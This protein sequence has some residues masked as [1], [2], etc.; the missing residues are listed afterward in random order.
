MGHAWAVGAID[1]YLH[2]LQDEGLDTIE[3]YT[4]SDYLLMARQLM[5]SGSASHYHSALEQCGRYPSLVKGVQEAALEHHQLILSMGDTKLIDQTVQINKPMVIHEAATMRFLM[6]MDLDRQL[7]TL[8]HLARTCY[9]LDINYSDFPVIINDLIDTLLVQ[10]R[11]CGYT[12]DRT[13][14]IDSKLLEKRLMLVEIVKLLH[15]QFKSRAAQIDPLL[16]QYQQIINC[17]LETGEL[18][19]V[20]YIMDLSQ[21]GRALDA[22]CMN[23]TCDQVRLAHLYLEQKG[24]HTYTLQEHVLSKVCARGDMDALL[25][26]VTWHSTKGHEESARG[27]IRPWRYI[28]KPMKYDQFKRLYKLCPT[29]E[30]MFMDDMCCMVDLDLVL[31]CL[32]TPELTDQFDWKVTCLHAARNGHQEIVKVLWERKGVLCK[33]C[34]INAL[35]GRHLQIINY[36]LSNDYELT[37]QDWLN[38]GELGNIDDYELIRPYIKADVLLCFDMVIVQVATTGGHTSLVRHIV[39]RHGRKLELSPQLGSNAFPDIIRYY[40]PW[41]VLPDAKLYQMIEHTVNCSNMDVLDL[42]FN[43]LT[44][45]QQRHVLEKVAPSLTAS[46]IRSNNM[47]MIYQLLHYGAKLTID[48]K[49]F[50]MKAF[51]E[52]PTLQT[53]LY[54]NQIGRSSSSSSSS[55]SSTSVNASIAVTIDNEHGNTSDNTGSSSRS[56]SIIS[57][58]RTLKRGSISSSFKSLFNRVSFSNNN[59]NNNQ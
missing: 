49:T 34:L 25:F 26:L 18:L 42:V 21:S 8:I 27:Q 1:I 6:N 39:E 11:A 48:E 40:Q 10:C 47:Q 37:F 46:M 32:D 3:G 57:S 58:V 43:N 54:L 41:K 20:P 55:S 14:I 4:S 35:Y 51:M 13:R 36:L 5:A 33:D 2:L 24:E 19:V 50:G 53:L 15:S 56:N 9:G 38:L 17:L 45:I 23:G 31:F 28:K 7:S 29:L 30:K 16:E 22:I 12:L 52:N 59:N 44:N